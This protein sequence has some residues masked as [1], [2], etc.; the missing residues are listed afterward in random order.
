MSLSRLPGTVGRL[1]I[2]ALRDRQMTR[3]SGAGYLADVIE[4][5]VNVDRFFMNGTLIAEDFHAVDEIADAIR[6]LRDEASERAV[7]LRCPRL[8]ELRRAPDPRKRIFDFM[9][10]HGGHGG[11]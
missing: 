4:N 11:H 8:Q 9:S 10:Q 5:S 1:W 2:V 7:F 3:E 6:F